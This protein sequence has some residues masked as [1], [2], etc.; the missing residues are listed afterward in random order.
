M[1]S[2]KSGKTPKRTNELVETSRERCE[3]KSGYYKTSWIELAVTWSTCLPKSTRYSYLKYNSSFT[4]SFPSTSST[5]PENAS[6]LQQ[7]LSTLSTLH[8]QAISELS[9]KDKELNSV[10]QRLSDL[11][12]STT[13]LTVTLNKRT[14]ELERELRW[15]KEGRQS[16]ERM[17]ELAR[18]EADLLRNTAVS[19]QI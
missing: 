11:A 12:Q 5:S 7:R 19:I 4:Q 1:I 6:I 16:A 9:E 14:A 17:E 18:K 15:A 3:M 10:Q 8:N 2:V 13:N